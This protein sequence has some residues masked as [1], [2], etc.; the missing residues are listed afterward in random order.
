MYQ[1][2]AGFVLSERAIAAYAMTAIDDG[3][4]IHG[5]EPVIDWEPEG[6]GVV[7]RTEHAEYRAR[8][9][10][11]SAGRLDGPA[12]RAPADLAVPERQVLLWTQPLRPERF[13]VGAFPVFILDDDG[14]EWYGFPSYGIPGFKFGRYHHRGQVIDPDHLDR[15]A[16]D[17]EDE[18]LLRDGLARYFPDANGPLLSWKTCIFTNTPD[19]HFIID[20][21]PG[22]AP[23]HPRLALL[24]PRLQV[25][26]RHRRGARRPGHGPRPRLRPVDVPAGPVRLGLSALTPSCVSG[27]RV[28]SAR[29]AAWSAV[30]TGPGRPSPTG[31]P[32]DVDGTDHLAHRRGQEHLGRREDVV[33]R[34]AT[35]LDRVPEA[36]GQ[37]AAD[38]IGSPRR[39]CPG[40][41]RGSGSGRPVAH[42]TLLVAPSRTHPSEASRIASSAPRRR[43]SASAATCTA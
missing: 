7:V 1:A 13:R 32:I 38:A 8:R 24:G 21:Y 35:L 25:R 30:A 41:A 6:D 26:E 29:S 12:G 42:Q 27:R 17:A 15:D 40:P 33:E 23:G 16:V 9:L 39:G 31:A 11:L 18:R 19:E 20:R 22:P 36:R 34:P 43:A 10:V 37:A 5:H 4:E 2:D 28:A 3:A 14:T